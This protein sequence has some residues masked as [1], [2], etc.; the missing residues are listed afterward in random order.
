MQKTIYLAALL[1]FSASLVG[2]TTYHK[3]VQ[4]VEFVLPKP[5]Q[6]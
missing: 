1:L 4:G 3:K 2:Q 6:S 5:F